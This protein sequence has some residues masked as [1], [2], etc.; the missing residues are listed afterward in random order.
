[1]L[2][3]TPCHAP[4]PPVI[5]TLPLYDAAVKLLDPKLPSCWGR[6]N[7]PEIVPVLKYCVNVPTRSPLSGT[8]NVSDITPLPTLAGDEQVTAPY[9]WPDE[10]GCGTVLEPA[11]GS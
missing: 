3:F 5:A 4:V 10:E 1:S 9:C 7:E 8:L 11:G 2:P 6:S